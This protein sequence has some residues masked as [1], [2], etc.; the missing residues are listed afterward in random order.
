MV[1][2]AVHEKLREKYGHYG[3]CMHWVEVWGAVQQKHGYNHYNAAKEVRVILECYVWEKK[4][5]KECNI[6]T[7]RPVCRL[8]EN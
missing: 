7:Y 3:R 2:K 1:S 4:C 8:L 6:K 5:L